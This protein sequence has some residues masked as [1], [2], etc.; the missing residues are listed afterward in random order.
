MLAVN[1]ILVKIW[2]TLLF[3]EVIERKDYICLL[4]VNCLL[5]CHWSKLNINN[6]AF[7]G[8]GGGGCF[9]KGNNLKSV[10]LLLS[11]ELRNYQNRE[12]SG[13]MSVT[14][15]LQSS[16]WKLF[17]S[18]ALGTYGWEMQIALGESWCSL[19][20]TKMKMVKTKLSSWLLLCLYLPDK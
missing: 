9:I 15:A 1:I 13:D 20:I 3:L 17:K 7:G 11:K 16:S 10:F 6:S 18:S 4:I 14:T 19:V 8:E 2:E 12:L 5:T